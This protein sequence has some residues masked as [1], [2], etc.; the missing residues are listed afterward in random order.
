[1]LNV[2][3]SRFLREEMK[4]LHPFCFLKRKVM[5]IFWMNNLL[6]FIIF[7]HVTLS[8]LLISLYGPTLCL[9]FPFSYFSRFYSTLH[10]LHFYFP[11]FSASPYVCLNRCAFLCLLSGLVSVASSIFHSAWLSQ[12]MYPYY[13]IAHTQTRMHSRTSVPTDSI[14]P[15]HSCFSLTPLQT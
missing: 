6:N 2:L 15:S 9:T 13:I 7:S 8:S 12:R 3:F 1:M 14:S 4:P 5:K 11:S 10:R